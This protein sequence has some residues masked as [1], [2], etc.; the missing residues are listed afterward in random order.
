MK[1]LNYETLKNSKFYMIVYKNSRGIFTI[2]YTVNVTKVAIKKLFDQYTC[3]ELIQIKKITLNEYIQNNLSFSEV[4]HIKDDVF[5]VEF[6]QKDIFKIDGLFQFDKIFN[7]SF[8]E[9]ELTGHEIQEILE[10]QEKDRDYLKDFLPES[11]QGLLDLI[12]SKKDKELNEM[13][14]IES[15]MEF[16]LM[17]LQDQR[18]QLIEDIN[19]EILELRNTGNYKYYLLDESA[20]SYTINYLKNKKSEIIK[21]KMFI[22]AGNAY[23]K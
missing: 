6:W 19:K 18:E 21:Y 23:K 22:N 20:L 11:D 14:K 17:E 7:I 9:Y 16:Q 5:N 1:K 15:D 3:F 2:N 13:L 4:E 12:I 10:I 8:P